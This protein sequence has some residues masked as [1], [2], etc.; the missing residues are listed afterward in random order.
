MD[1]PHL[2]REQLDKVHELTNLVEEK[3]DLASELLRT[4][5]DRFNG[6]THTVNRGGTK[7]EVSEKTLWTEVFHLGTQSEAAEILRKVHPDVFKTYKEQDDAASELKKY[8]VTE[9]GID[10]TKMTLSDY[11][12]LTE[13]MFRLLIDERFT[14]TKKLKVEDLNEP[15]EIRVTKE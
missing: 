1:T 11:L 12:F 9:I 14:V 3:K 15:G 8:V 5:Q 2:T 7:S 6:R 10:P 4:A 13:E